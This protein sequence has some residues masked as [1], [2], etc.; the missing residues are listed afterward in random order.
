MRFYGLVPGLR[1][2]LMSLIDYR[3]FRLVA[4]SILPIGTFSPHLATPLHCAVLYR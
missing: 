3:G 4:M 2:P 1:I